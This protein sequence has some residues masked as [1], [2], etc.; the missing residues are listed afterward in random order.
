[1]SEKR[2]KCFRDERNWCDPSCIAY[3]I[4]T[5]LANAACTFIKAAE[6]TINAAKWSGPE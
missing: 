4:P 6:A 1:M 3:I 2:K 5:K